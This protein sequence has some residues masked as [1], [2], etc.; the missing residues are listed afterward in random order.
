MRGAATDGLTDSQSAAA[1]LNLQDGVLA[2]KAVGADHEAADET[3]GRV[4]ALPRHRVGTGELA[5]PLQQLCILAR[6]R[7]QAAGAAAA[8]SHVGGKVA[9]RIEFFLRRLYRRRKGQAPP[10][11]GRQ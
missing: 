9:H 11:P 2:A 1:R 7:D 10:K 4:L 3:E 8:G 6:Q 5:G